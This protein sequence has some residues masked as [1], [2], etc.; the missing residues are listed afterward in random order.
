MPDGYR[1]WVN[2]ARTLLVR[3]WAEGLV[4]VAERDNPNMTWG[5]PK[6]LPSLPKWI[7]NLREEGAAAA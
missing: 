7:E 3:Q 6:T 2:D 4:E 5:P 1:L